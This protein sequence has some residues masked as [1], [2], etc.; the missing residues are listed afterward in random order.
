MG[1]K[2]YRHL[3][4][5]GD[6]PEVLINQG[7]DYAFYSVPNQHKRTYFFLDGRKVPEKRIRDM[8]G[9]EEHLRAVGTAKVLYYQGSKIKFSQDTP[10]GKLT[11]TFKPV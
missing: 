7:Y 6:I 1:K 9:K 2:V 3:L 4:H 8:L 10:Q 11:I 5:P